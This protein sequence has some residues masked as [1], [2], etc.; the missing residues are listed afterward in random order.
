MYIHEHGDPVNVFPQYVSYDSS[1]RLREGASSVE[2]L[3]ASIAAGEISKTD[4]KVSVQIDPH[5]VV[6]N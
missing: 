5:T 3:R 4:V 6:V 2:G 1:F